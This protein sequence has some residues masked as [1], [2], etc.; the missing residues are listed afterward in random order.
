[1]K[2][3]KWILL[4]VISDNANNSADQDFS[5]FIKEYENVSW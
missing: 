4:R 1:M 2:N 5:V 3:L